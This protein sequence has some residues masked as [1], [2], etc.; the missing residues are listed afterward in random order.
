MLIIF[1]YV[2]YYVL[3]DKVGLLASSVWLTW[4]KSLGNIMSVYKIS[5]TAMIFVLFVIALVDFFYQRWEYEQKI[6]M[7]KEDIKDEMK[8]TDGNPEVKRRR[9]DL[10]YLLLQR[11]ASKTVPEATVIINNPTHIS[12]ALRY[13]RGK[14]E[15]PVVVAKGEEQLALY[16]RQI[17]KEHDIPMIE[18]K[19]L[20]RALFFNVDVN[21]TIPPDMFEAVAAVLRHLIETKQLEL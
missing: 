6:M 7:K 4:E 13:K 10:M 3:K 11:D 1:S 2:A 19:P 15:F 18:N 9:R 21:N 17:A 20:A 16:I 14:D 5:L 8:E 12:V